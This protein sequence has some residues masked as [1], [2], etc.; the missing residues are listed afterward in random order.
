MPTKNLFVISPVGDPDSDIRQQADLILEDYI[1]PAAEKAAENYSVYRDDGQHEP[2]IMEVII[3]ALERDPMV[4]AYLGYPPWNPNVMW[5]VG[6]RLATYRPIV[7]LTHVNTELPFDLLDYRCVELPPYDK[8]ERKDKVRDT[9]IINQIAEALEEQN[10]SRHIWQSAYAVA[11][12]QIDQTPG[13]R[14]EERQSIFTASSEAADAL[15]HVKGALT[16]MSII[17]AHDSLLPRIEEF[18]VDPFEAEQE[19]LIGQLY[20][21]SG[22]GRVYRRVQAMV[23]LIFKK[24]PVDNVDAPD[25]VDPQFRSRA[26]LPI[27]VQNVQQQNAL[28]L[29]MLYFEVTSV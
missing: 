17:Y 24:K 22:R 29:R 5:E 1:R 10:R 3:R 7:L 20:M 18:Q 21:G 12:I 4:I 16:G 27:I 14:A 6:F 11:E 15:F 2:R 9:R 8:L 25:Y 19:R 26:F 13:I 28:F 23:P